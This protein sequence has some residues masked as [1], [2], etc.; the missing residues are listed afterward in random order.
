MDR[1][2]LWVRTNRRIG[3]AVALFAL[4]VQLV[5]SFGHVHLDKAA[6]FAPAGISAPQTAGGGDAPPDPDRRPGAADFCAICATISLASTQLLPEPTRLTPPVA[7][8]PPGSREFE[9]ALAASA[10]HLL[11]QAR[12]PPRARLLG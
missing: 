10:P 7:H 2:M 8:S 5:L 12:A 6:L 3:A 4:A 11:S 9:A 1:G